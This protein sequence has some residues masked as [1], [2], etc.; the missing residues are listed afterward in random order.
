MVLLSAALA[1][2]ALGSSAVG[3]IPNPDDQYR[4][5]WGTDRVSSGVRVPRVYPEMVKTGFNT[6]I[7]YL[8]SHLV[9]DTVA[10][11]PLAMPK[12]WYEDL[13]AY[14]DRC[15]EDGVS[16][17]SQFDIGRRRPICEKSPRRRKDGSTNASNLDAADRKS[18]RLNSSH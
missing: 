8:G 3:P 16:V 5:I 2:L 12:S 6:L 1:A 13:R 17:M 14:L 4:F 15:L 10:D 7:P 9:Y 18:T 11:K